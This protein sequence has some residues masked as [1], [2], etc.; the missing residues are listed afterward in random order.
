MVSCI[1]GRR[2]VFGFNLATWLCPVREKV[3]PARL[4][5]GVSAKMFA[6][7]AQNG[8][9]SAFYGALGELFRD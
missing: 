6:L 9:N 2:G 4:D 8:P 7:R 1:S 5:V 3:R